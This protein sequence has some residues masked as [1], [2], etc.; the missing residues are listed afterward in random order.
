MSFMNHFVM[1]VKRININGKVMINYS[2]DGYG[3]GKKYITKFE[4]HIL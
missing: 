1:F 4:Y 2:Y 3:R